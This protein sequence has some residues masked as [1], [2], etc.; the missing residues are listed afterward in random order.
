LPD[1]ENKS[2]TQSHIRK[3]LF[4]V[5]NI[6]IRRIFISNLYRWRKKPQ[7]FSILVAVL[8]RIPAS[9]AHPGGKGRIAALNFNPISLRELCQ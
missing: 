9:R 7:L 1:A 6:A 3:S 2:P 5:V 4:H 8:P